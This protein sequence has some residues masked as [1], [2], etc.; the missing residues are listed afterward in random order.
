MENIEIIIEQMQIV[1]KIINLQNKKTKNN[2]IKKEIKKLE[3]KY[4]NL[5]KILASRQEIY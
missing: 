5:T 4:N 2:K 3:N 1:N